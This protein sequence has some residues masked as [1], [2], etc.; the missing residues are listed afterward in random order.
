MAWR[1]PVSATVLLFRQ[2]S[3]WN[4]LDESSAVVKL[5]TF[6]Q[7]SPLVQKY[8][9][10]HIAFEDPVNGQ[11]STL[12]PINYLRNIAIKHVKTRQVYYIDVDIIPSVS[13]EEMSSHLAMAV[14]E[15]KDADCGKCAFITPT[16]TVC[17]G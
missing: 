15:L 6:Y 11:D 9:D 12:Y 2:G 1:G 4:K 14:R 8:I 7:S 16:F 5:I 13:A 17:F 10:I 3:K